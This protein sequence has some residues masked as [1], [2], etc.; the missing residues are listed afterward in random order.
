MKTRHEFQLEIE[1][2]LAEIEQEIDEM[3]RERRKERAQ[4]HKNGGARP[5][6]ASILPG[7]DEP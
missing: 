4:A 6:G 2:R 3:W 5:Q 1:D 7:D